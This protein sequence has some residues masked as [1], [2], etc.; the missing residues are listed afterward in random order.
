M[1]RSLFLSAVIMHVTTQHRSMW[2]P[3]GCWQQI[4]S[5]NQEKTIN[6]GQFRYLV[7]L[8]FNVKKPFSFWL[9]C[10]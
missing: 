9:L 3:C 4:V 10:M 8:D 5:I 7:V 2:I 6:I 1:Q